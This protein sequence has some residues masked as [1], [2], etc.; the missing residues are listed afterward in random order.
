MSRLF[1]FIA[2]IGL[3]LFSASAYAGEVA[4]SVNCAPATVQCAP[5]CA[6]AAVE[7]VA[8][9]Q[10]VTTTRVVYGGGIFRFGLFRG[11]CARRQA[12]RA[13]RRAALCF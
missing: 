6:P 2:V 12:R 1:S 5:Q 3:L 13:A 7:A 11:I 4:V 8:V 9:Q 10:T